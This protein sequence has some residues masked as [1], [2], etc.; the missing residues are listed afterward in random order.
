[1]VGLFDEPVR[2][3]SG[4]TQG[5]E[6]DAY[7]ADLHVK[8][9]TASLPPELC[10]A[11]MP[12]VGRRWVSA[13]ASLEHAA[14]WAVALR[15]PKGS[16]TAVRWWDRARRLRMTSRAAPTR[17]CGW[18]ARCGR[19]RSGIGGT[20]IEY[21]VTGRDLTFLGAGM[22]RTAELFFAAGAREVM[23]GVRGLPE[24]IGPNE[25]GVFDRAPTDPSSYAFVLSHLFGT[26]R[27]SVRPADGV[28]GSDFSVHGHRGLYVVDSSVFPTNLGVNPQLTIMS[29]AALAAERIEVQ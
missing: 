6:I 13:I 29:M 22:R 20:R 11:L 25:L 18:A 27:M 24:R 14:F 3:W 16:A 10:I 23:P 19:V 12:G 21:S 26:A 7:R 9:E 15:A 5:Y 17:S 4:A 2:V 28:V 1:M 8:I